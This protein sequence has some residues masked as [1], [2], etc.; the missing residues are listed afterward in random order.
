MLD[1][2]L[3]QSLNAGQPLGQGMTLGKVAF[4]RQQQFLE[5]SSSEGNECFSSEGG[6]DRTPPQP[7]QYIWIVQVQAPME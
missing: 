7:L 4:F 2:W 3:K 5:G 6:Q 1:P